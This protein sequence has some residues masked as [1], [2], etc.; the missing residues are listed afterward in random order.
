MKRYFASGIY[1]IK[2]INNN[3][4]YIGSAIDLDSRIRGHRHYLNKGKHANRHLQASWN[5]HGEASFSFIVIER[6]HKSQLLEREQYWIDFYDAANGGGYN[7]RLTASSNL[8]I[9]FSDKSK[10]KM[11]RFGKDNP[12]YGKTHSE[13][14][15]AKLSKLYKGVKRSEEIKHNISIGH[16]GRPRS[17]E[18][19]HKI[20]LT[21]KGRVLPE[22]TKRK[23]SEAAYQ[24]WQ[25][26]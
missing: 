17:E 14:F 18:I 2:N 16:I 4:V 12:F 6:V 13:E 19:K 11:V 9:K 25:R 23:M 7:L 5:K 20:S 1:C 26:C 8:G 22:E 3:K 24:R 10:L 15:K 21:L